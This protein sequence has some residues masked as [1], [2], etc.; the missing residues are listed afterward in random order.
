M[1]RMRWH[2][3]GDIGAGRG[4]AHRPA[5]RIPRLVIQ[6]VSAA[7]CNGYAAG[8]AQGKIFTGPT[9]A[10]CLPVLNCYSCPGALGACPIGALQNAIGGAWRHIPFYVLGSLMLFGILLGRLV[11]GFLCPFGLVQD[12]L[13]KIPTRKFRVP[14]HVDRAL[15]LLKYV[16]LFGMVVGLS[17]LVTTEAGVTPPFFCE[18]LC[19]AGTLG[20]GIPLLL[21]NEDLRAVAGALFDWKLLVLV[22]ILVA[23]VLVPRPFCRYLCPLGALYGL[24]NRFSFYRMGVDEGRCVGCGACDR[25]CPMRVEA[26]ANPNSPECI[27]CGVCRKACPTGAIAAGW[28]WTAEKPVKSAVGGEGRQN[29]E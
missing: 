5:R 3:V 9:K 21:A 17:L 8:F 2:R 19:P 29:E 16:V 28:S 22:A 11:C 25:A 23:A 20:A 10:V 15:R 12:L 13:H 27:R 1:P 24:F 26:R 4:S 18:F 7:V 14:R 6:L